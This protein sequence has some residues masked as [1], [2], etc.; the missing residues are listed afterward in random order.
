MR[1]YRCTYCNAEFRNSN[2]EVRD[3]HGHITCDGCYCDGCG[4]GHADDAERAKCA[5]RYGE[6]EPEDF[7]PDVLYDLRRDALVG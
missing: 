6:D 4:H 2:G 1:L 3:L 5:E 7:D